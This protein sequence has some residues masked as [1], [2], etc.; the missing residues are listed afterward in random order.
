MQALKHEPKTD[1]VAGTFYDP[2]I[3]YAGRLTLVAVSRTLCRL[4]MPAKE[5]KAEL[6]QQP[7]GTVGHHGQKKFSA[8]P[9]HLRLIQKRMR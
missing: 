1:S 2:A 5:H 8:H 3:S 6:E 4:A 9:L 7:F